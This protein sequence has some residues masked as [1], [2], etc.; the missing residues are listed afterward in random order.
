MNPT[1]VVLWL[2]VVILVGLEVYAITDD[3]HYK[4][5]FIFLVLMLYAVYFLR[6]KIN[7]LPLHFGLLAVF[8]L[9]H[10]LGMFNLYQTY[11]LGL[12]YDHWVTAISA[13]LPRSSSFVH[14][15]I[16][17][18]TRRRSSSLPRWL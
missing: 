11:P 14:I 3:S 4:W 17:S 12:E 1:K 15:T 13:L 10:D 7:L 8:L 6:E 2:T 16:T 9:L 18:S 5:D